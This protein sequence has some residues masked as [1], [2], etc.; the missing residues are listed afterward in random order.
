MSDEDDLIGEFLVESRENLDRLDGDLVA[1]EENPGDRERISSIFRTI[2]TI[3]GTCGF[4]G[5]DKLQRVTH[6]GENLLAKMRDGVLSM[7][8][9]IASALLEMVDAVRKMLAAIEANGAEGEEEYATLVQKLTE[10]Q[11]EGARAVPV[12]PVVKK[13][14]VR[15]APVTPSVPPAGPAAPAVQPRDALA[16]LK[17]EIAARAKAAAGSREP[18]HEVPNEPAH[19]P[20]H[21]PVQPAHEQAHEPP[22]GARTPLKPTAVDSS[23]RVDVELLDRLMNLVGELVLTRNQVLQV[24][25]GDDKA[26]IGQAV[27]R[28]DL[29]TSELQEGVMKTRMQPIGNVWNKFP[30]VVRDLAVSL[31]KKV[32]VVMEGPE[33]ELDKTLLEAIKDP[34]THLVRNS[35]D[36]GIEL[37]AERRAAGKHEEGTLLLRAFHEGGQ[38][39]IEITDD[40]RGINTERVKNKAVEKGLLAADRAARMSEKELVNLIFL[41]G[42]STAQKVTNI[43]GRGVG[44]DVVKTNIEKI[45]GS[46]DI[47]NEIGKGATIRVKIPLTLA[48][49]PALMVSTAGD[50]YAIP[51]VNLLELVR[52]EAENA[53]KCIEEVRGV[54]VYRLRNRLLPLVRLSDVLGLPPPPADPEGEELATSI[55][56]LQADGHR[57]GLVVD[58]VNDTEEIVVKPLGTKLKGLGIFAGATIRG[59]GRIALILDVM[60][61]AQRASVW[62]EGS[63]PVRDT[64][65]EES[66]AKKRSG[67]RENL[68]LLEIGANQRVAVPLRLVARLEEIPLERVEREGDCEVTQYREE[69]MPLLDLGTLLGAGSSERQEGG[70]LPVIVHARNGR[71]VGLVVG[72][73]IDILEETYVLDR[74]LR[75]HGIQGSAVVAGRVTEF[76]D[77]EELVKSA[78]L[79]LEHDGAEAR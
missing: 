1:L 55:V 51:Q 61:L 62:K 8:E 57:F 54:R 14:E 49:I 6:V 25:A 15:A 20:A 38:V 66:P 12:E 52:L 48:I 13:S 63:E 22:E 71:S 79:V 45:G 28:L 75:R 43:S 4:L 39:N 27:Q 78:S 16:A 44:M 53:K 34:L 74:K 46:I 21:E 73:I 29:V 59:D 36:H 65:S 50:R 10:L 72:R 19:Q 5:F 7:E 30:R 67:T 23:I 9:S 3:K 69:I 2:H 64:S 24:G 41:P 77:V 17:A 47:Q 60:G 35:V 68:L 32:K 26:A 76:I 37:P 31:E 18:S 70:V 11:E 33:T 42:L 40:G 56:V 58:E